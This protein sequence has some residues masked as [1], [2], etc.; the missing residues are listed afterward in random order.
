MAARANALD[1]FLAEIAAFGEAYS[2][3]E[4]DFEQQIVF[5]E[6]DAVAGHAGFDAQNI[7]RLRADPCCAAAVNR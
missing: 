2:V 5:G 7:L 6:I 4:G 3:I 1:D